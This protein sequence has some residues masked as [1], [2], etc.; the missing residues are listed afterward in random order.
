MLLEEFDQLLLH[1]VSVFLVGK[2]TCL[3]LPFGRRRNRRTE[4]GV[5][6]TG[7]GHVI[8]GRLNIASAVPEAIRTPKAAVGHSVWRYTDC[9]GRACSRDVADRFPVTVLSPTEVGRRCTQG[10]TCRAAG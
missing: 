7:E 6:A 5:P 9:P 4:A 1:A 3:L 8:S 10:Q 2:G